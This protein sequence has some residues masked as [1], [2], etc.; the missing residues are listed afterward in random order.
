MN[1]VIPEDAARAKALLE[2]KRGR[3]ILSQALTLAI[4]HLETEQAEHREV[5]NLADMRLLRD[6]CFPLYHV[7]RKF[8]RRWR[9][10]LNQQ[11]EREASDV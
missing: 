4:D 2:S 9:E 3:Y 6:E 11:R 5:T 7:T 10:L 8:T 1:H